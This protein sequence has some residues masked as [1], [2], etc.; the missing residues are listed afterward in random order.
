MTVL[1]A[2]GL[3]FLFAFAL[4]APARADEAALKAIIAKFATAKGFPAI[5]AVVRELGATGDPTVEKALTALSEGALS[6]RKADS[7][8][9]IVKEAGAAISLFDPITGEAAGQAA[10]AELTKIKVN[11]GLRSVIRDVL[12]TLTLGSTDPAVRLA[13]AENSVPQ[14]RSGGDRIAGCGDRQGDRRRR[15]GAARAGE[16]I[17]RAGVRPRRS[18]Q[19]RRDRG[20]RGS[21]ATARRCRC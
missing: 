11:N 13:A 12:G 8:V 14:S 16:G 3:L 20:A 4:A 21:A 5:E 6:V 18:R 15:Q 17:G 1:R 9:F 19:A 10:K 2:I 7:Q